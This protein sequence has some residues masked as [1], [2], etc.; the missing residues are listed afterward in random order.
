MRRLLCAVS[1]GLVV[2]MIPA[3]PAWAQNFV[4]NSA[5]TI[6]KGNFKL[7]GYPVVLLGEDG[8]D[9]SWGFGGRFGYGFTD[10]FD[11]E[12]KVGIFDGFNLYGADAELWI[13]KGDVDVSLALG[14]HVADLDGGSD[15]KALDVTGIVGGHV[16]SRLE[17]Y[18]GLNFSF[19]SLDDS[20]ENFTR[21]HVVP[22]LE[23]AVSDDLDLLAEV[24]IG[25]GDDS[26]NYLA[27]GLAY[28]VR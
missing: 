25:I 27:F 13:L 15:S 8:A 28:Y 23:Y 1:T 20:D 26:P 17:L 5:E 19:E 18:A 21:T 7:A 16:T 12:A 6:N 10:G 9:D 11:V 4:M 22:G 14:G 24:G 2:A 3:T